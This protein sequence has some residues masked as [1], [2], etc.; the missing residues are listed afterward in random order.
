MIYL[1]VEIEIPSSDSLQ[2]SLDNPRRQWIMIQKAFFLYSTFCCFFNNCT[3]NTHT[4]S[5]T[6]KISLWNERL[7]F[8]SHSSSCQ[9]LWKSAFH[10]AFSWWCFLSRIF[11]LIAQLALSKSSLLIL[12]VAI[13]AI[14]CSNERRAREPKRKKLLTRKILHK[15]NFQWQAETGSQQQ[16]NSSHRIFCFV[17]FF[18]VLIFITK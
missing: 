15:E 13:C 1:A 10:T 14:Y 7:L 18:I 9:C 17:T 16:W 6:P 11:F 12:F 5:I 2:L 4:A 3:W 8:H